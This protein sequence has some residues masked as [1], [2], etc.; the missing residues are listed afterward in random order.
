MKR[1]FKCKCCGKEV[2]YSYNPQGGGTT[3]LYCSA[4]CRSKQWARDNKEKRKASVMKYDSKPENKIKK[5]IR[6][7]EK[8]YW[9]R[10]TPEY[11]LFARARRRARDKGIEFD[12][13]LE[14]IEIPE[15]CP[16]LGIPLKQ[17]KV[18][19]LDNSPSLDRINSNKG[20]TKN[21]IWVI[22]HKANTAKSNLSLSELKELVENLEE[23][24]VEQKIH[25]ERKG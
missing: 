2:T 21:N 11:K 23:A 13:E 18:Q 25:E 1:A 15:L 12:L 5:S 22:S 19:C 9:L 4:K 7:K 10:E 3:R 20:Y 8:K 14:Q 16:L 17:G 6:Q 24:I